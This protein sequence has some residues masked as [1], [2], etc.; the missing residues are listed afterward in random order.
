LSF[1]SF[2]DFFRE[3]AA[4]GNRRTIQTMRGRR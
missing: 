2:L 3:R 4:C 1:C